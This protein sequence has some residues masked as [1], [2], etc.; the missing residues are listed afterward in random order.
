LNFYS[1]RVVIP[2]SDLEITNYWQQEK[3]IY[4]LIEPDLSKK[5]HL[6][7]QQVLGT[8]NNWQLITKKNRV[9]NEF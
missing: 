8:T 2:A 7:P 5:L 1:D 4:L 6:E 3:N 9:K